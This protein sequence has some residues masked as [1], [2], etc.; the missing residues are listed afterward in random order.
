MYDK[1]LYKRDVTC[2]WTP[3]PLSQTVTPSRTP[4]PLERG[5]L[6]GRPRTI[7]FITRYL[8][9]GGQHVK[10]KSVLEVTVKSKQLLMFKVTFYE[11]LSIDSKIVKV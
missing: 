11:A 10:D 9:L 1:N 4:S 2:S 3:S 6:Y 7:H 5:V 8:I